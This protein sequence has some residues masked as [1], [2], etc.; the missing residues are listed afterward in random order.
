MQLVKFPTDIYD[1][2][3]VKF[4]EGSYH[5]LNSETQSLVTA[6]YADLIDDDTTTDHAELL[7]ARARIAQEHADAAMDQAIELAV[8]AEQAQALADAAKPVDK[9]TEKAAAEKAAAEQA[10]AEKAATDKAAADKAAA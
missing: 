5:P 8:Q 1:N 9:K 6:G 4:V 3:V 7:Q 10:A 2:G